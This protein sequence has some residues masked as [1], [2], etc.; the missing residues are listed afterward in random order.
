MQRWLL[1][2]ALVSGWAA[3]KDHSLGFEEGEQALAPAFAPDPGLLESAERHAEV[4]AEGVVADGPGAQLLRPP[5]GSG[6]LPHL[7]GVRPPG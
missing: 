3:L 2:W 7:T 1:G 4:G 5:R 6:R